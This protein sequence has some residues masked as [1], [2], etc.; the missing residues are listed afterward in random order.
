MDLKHM[1]VREVRDLI[2]KDSRRIKDDEWL[3]IGGWIN[4]FLKSNP[5]LEEKEMFVPL[6]CG[7][8]V[9]IICDGIM[10]WR[11]SICIKCKKQQGCGKGCCSVYQKNKDCTG[12]YQMKSGRTR[13]QSVRILNQCSFRFQ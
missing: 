9:T 10:R 8:M 1:T 3:E 4:K 5:P 11:N 7:E 6:G 2:M 12:A 13:M